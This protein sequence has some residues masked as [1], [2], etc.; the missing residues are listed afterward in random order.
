MEQVWLRS[1][2]RGGSSSA[3]GGMFSGLCKPPLRITAECLLTHFLALMVK[4]LRPVLPALD[5]EAEVQKG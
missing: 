2:D 4:P 5:R 3:L 1:T